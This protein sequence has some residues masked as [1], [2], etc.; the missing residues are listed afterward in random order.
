MNLPRGW[1]G[2]RSPEKSGVGGGGMGGEC[3]ATEQ[4]CVLRSVGACLRRRRRW[5]GPVAA[6]VPLCTSNRTNRRPHVPRRHAVSVVSVQ[7]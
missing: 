5:R 4:I 7:V 3:L 2:T 1:V 6:V